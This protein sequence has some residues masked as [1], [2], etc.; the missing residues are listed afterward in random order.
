MQH[1]NDVRDRIIDIA[2]RIVADE[3]VE[4]LSIRKITGEMD[5]SAGIVYHYF[6]NKEQILSCIL[7]DGYKKIMESTGPAGSDLPADE[8]FRVTALSFM[9]GVLKWP[10]VYKAIMLDSSPQILEF[11][12]VLGEGY[13]EKHPALMV[14]VNTL[15][16]GIS[17]GLFTPCDTQ[18][19]AQAIWSAM[20]GLHMRLII[21]KSVS[22]EH[23]M[24]LIKCQLELIINGLKVN[25]SEK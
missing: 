12:S 18:L 2:K 9:E 24:N 11:T 8:K 13:C 22:H 10:N 15:E 5:Y 14:M 3:G 20:Y 4:A 19:T 1:S 17:K 21:E 7:Q 23:A 6:K 16:E 25:K